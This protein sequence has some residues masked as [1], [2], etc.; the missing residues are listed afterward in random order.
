[1]SD[2][3][4][5]SDAETPV[6]SREPPPL[7]EGRYTGTTALAPFPMSRLAPAFQLVDIAREIEKADAQIAIVTGGK[8]LLIAD[9]IRALQE[10]AHKLLERAELDAKLHRALCRF[11]KKV[12]DVYH[13]YKEP[14]DSTWFS[15]IAPGEWLV[16]KPTFVG[17]FRLEADQSFTPLDQIAEQDERQATIRGL[18]GR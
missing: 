1:M 14:D 16:H 7:V 12:G 9:Q 17:S 18:L 13:L 5:D 11:E 6:P 15:L 10:K 3:K 2:P 8:L 4:Q